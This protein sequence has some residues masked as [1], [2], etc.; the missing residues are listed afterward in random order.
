MR[1]A[2]IH[3][4]TLFEDLVGAPATVAGPLQTETSYA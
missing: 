2:L 1:Q 3:Y 4:R